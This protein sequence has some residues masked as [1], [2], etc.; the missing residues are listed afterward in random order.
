[1]RDR[2]EEIIN[3]FLRDELLVINSFIPRKRK[4]LDELLNEDYPHVQTKD[5]GIHMFRKSELRLAKELIGDEGRKLLLPI[6]LELRPEMTQ[7][8]AVVE[9]PVAAQLIAKITGLPPESPL[10]LY[11]AH[12]NIVRKKIGTLIQY[13]ISPSSLME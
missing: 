12:L 10:Y 9:D 1:M 6:F 11:P 2:E 13:L 7:T 5:G 8:I 4:T 3:Y